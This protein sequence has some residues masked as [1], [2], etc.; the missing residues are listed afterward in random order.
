MLA[1]ETYL[2]Q[3]RMISPARQ[4]ASHNSHG[5][6][7]TSSLACAYGKWWISEKAMPSHQPKRADS[8]GLLPDSSRRHQ[9]LQHASYCARA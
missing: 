2:T 9:Q 8:S 7:P 3:L 4:T 1:V 5:K 6:A